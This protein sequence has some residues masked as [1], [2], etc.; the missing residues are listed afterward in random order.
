MIF[1]H[2]F[3]NIHIITTGNNGQFPYTYCFYIDD[4]IKT[5][6]DTP[7]DA[8]FVDFF[9]D[10]PVDLILNTHFHPDHSGCNYLFPQTT[11]RAHPQDI[12]ALRSHEIFAD[13]YGFKKFQAPPGIMNWFNWQPSHVNGTIADGEIIDLGA[14]QLEVLHTPGHTPGHC[15][16]YWREKE[17]L[18]SGDIDLTAFGPWYGNDTS[19]VDQTIASIEKVIELNPKVILSSHKGMIDT[20][21]KKRLI[22]YLDRIYTSEKKILQ[23]LSS[24]L[25]L[26]E[27]TRHKIIYT[28]W[29]K[30]ESTFF[31]FEK[32]SLDVHLR[33][34]LKL[35]LVKESSGKYQSLVKVND[36]HQGL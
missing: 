32:V 34:L 16:F 33:R 23:A 3:D 19:D 21:V 20:N 10:R 14:I 28:R 15:C 18:F 25:T 30:P 5:I 8:R 2:L 17:V 36:Y 29:G 9:A 1:Q 11:I 22:K 26:D 35:G 13:F 6:I 27:L 4:H 12:P 24:P 7:L 31:F